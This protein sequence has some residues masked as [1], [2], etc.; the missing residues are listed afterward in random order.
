MVRSALHEPNP[1]VINGGCYGSNPSSA[2][3]NRRHIK[4]TAL[5]IKDRDFHY[6]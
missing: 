5:A 2:N 1:I 6:I 4:I 3:S